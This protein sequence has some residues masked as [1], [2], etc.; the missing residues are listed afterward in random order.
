MD[1]APGRPF[2]ARILGDKKQIFF[3]GNVQNARRLAADVTMLPVDLLGIDAAILFSDILVTGE[4][5]G[6][7][8]SFH[9]GSRPKIRQPGSHARQM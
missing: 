7:D 8:L 1:D 9:A 2:Y 5:M 4:A 6:G 3:P